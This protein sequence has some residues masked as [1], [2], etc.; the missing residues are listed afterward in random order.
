LPILQLLDRVHEAIL[1]EIVGPI[2]VA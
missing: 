1:N 2:H